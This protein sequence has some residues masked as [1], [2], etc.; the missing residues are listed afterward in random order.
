ML[1]FLSGT[2]YLAWISIKMLVILFSL[3]TLILWARDK[4]AAIFQ[5]T[6]SINFD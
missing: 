2:E 6:F 4:M 5:T 3:E 1:F